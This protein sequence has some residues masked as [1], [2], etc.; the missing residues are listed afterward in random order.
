M[1]EMNVKNEVKNVYETPEM[2]VIELGTRTQSLEGSPIN[3]GPGS[4][5]PDD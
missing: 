5:N 3:I 1:K 4:G 2:I